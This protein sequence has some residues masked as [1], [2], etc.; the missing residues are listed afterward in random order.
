[1]IDHTEYTITPHVLIENTPALKD[2]YY[3]VFRAA[4]VKGIIAS[5]ETNSYQELKEK[6]EYWGKPFVLIGNNNPDN[7]NNIG[8]NVYEGGRTIGAY[9]KKNKRQKAACIVGSYYSHEL[10]NITLSP[11]RN[12]FLEGFN[13]KPEDICW[14]PGGCTF[15][16]GYNAFHAMRR[17]DQDI[18]CVFCENDILA[19]GFIRAAVES[20]VKIPED[21]C[22]IG[23]DNIDAGKFITPSLSTI[24]FPR[25]QMG[26]AAANGIIDMVNKKTSQINLNLTCDLIIRDS[27]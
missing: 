4:N 5:S 23:F 25:Y 27:A 22:V 16:D 20:G 13:K 9:F 26:Q 17:M 6:L 21:I 3:D 12:G 1:V 14:V 2:F 7:F 19:I 24:D 15:L 18:D 10:V 11:K 8:F